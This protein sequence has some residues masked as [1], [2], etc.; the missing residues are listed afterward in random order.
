MGE[1]SAP[2]ALGAVFPDTNIGNGLSWE[3]SH[4]ST[5]G[6]Y[7]ASMEAGSPS[8]LFAR[9]ALT[10]GVDPPG[11]DYYGDQSYAGG[12]RGYCFQK[13]RPLASKAADV[14]NLPRSMGWW[15]AHNFV[16]MAA[17]LKISQRRPDLGPAFLYILEDE[18]NLREIAAFVHDV[19]PGKTEPQ[20]IVESFHRMPDFLELENVTPQRLAA[21][22]QNQVQAK[23]HIPQIDIDGAAGLIEDAVHLID[24]SLDGFLGFAEEEV[25]EATEPVP[26][27]RSHWRAQR[28]TRGYLD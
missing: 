17:D 28:Y 14:C 2:A 1:V 15:K 8:R 22:Y 6:M 13:A 23:H 3:T 26:L 19:L 7:E 24:D 27:E 21:K 25:R 4:C 5:A 11:L 12:E 20:V 18:L 10:H 16:E 9:G